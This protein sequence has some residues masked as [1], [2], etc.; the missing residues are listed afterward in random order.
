MPTHDFDELDAPAPLLKPWQAAGFGGG[1]TVISLLFT[2]FARIDL[3]DPSLAIPT[4]VTVGFGYAAHYLVA[5]LLI[6]QHRRVR[7]ARRDMMR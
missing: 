5:E 2:A 4:V 7:R 6:Q 1:L 3:F